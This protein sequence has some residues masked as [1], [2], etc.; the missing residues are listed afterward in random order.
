VRGLIVALVL[1]LAGTGARAECRL[2]LSIGLD[3]S[4]SVD[5]V[6]YR[7]QIDGLAAALLDRDVQAAFLAMPGAPVRL[8]VYEWAGAN[9]QRV[10]LGWREITSVA[11]L[12]QVA[13]RLRTV[14]RVARE[15]AT[16]IGQA[17]LFGAAALRQQPACWQHKLDL[18][19]DGRNN[20]GA[21]PSGL[22]NSVI[23]QGVTINALIVGSDSLSGDDRR[24]A[25]IA[26]LWAYFKVEVIRGPQAFVEVAVGFQDFQAAMTRKLLKELQVMAVSQLRIR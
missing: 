7:L 5:P 16:A 21:A 6:E 17:M 20:V 24:Q 14:P 12:E 3:V 9:S 15:P 23:L 11:D 26:A 25:E 4:G 2:A 22:R 18:S 8:H 1:L 10:L 13:A 19:G